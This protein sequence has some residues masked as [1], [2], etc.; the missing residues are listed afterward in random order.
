MKPEKLIAIVDNFN[1][2][3]DK[4]LPDVLGI[5]LRYYSQTHFEIYCVDEL[6]V[7]T[8]ADSPEKLIWSEISMG[9]M[10]TLL[11]E[12]FTKAYAEYLVKKLKEK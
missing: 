12:R 6:L 9:E 4:L 5:H 3:L 2:K 1:N 10:E 7:G 11:A 8:V